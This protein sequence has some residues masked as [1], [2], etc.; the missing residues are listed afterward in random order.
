[1]RNRIFAVLVLAIVAGGGLAYATYNAINTNQ[2]VKT[3]NAPTDPVVVA[4]NDLAL[5]TELKK[6]DLMIVNFPKGSAPEGAFS[7]PS[8]L[9]GRGV[10]VPLVKNEI[11]I[12]AKLSSKEEGAG[13]PPIIPDGMRAVSV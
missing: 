2:K 4:S 8:D 9:V 10:I 5:G 11:I 7:S 6:E 1:M 12:P 13:L 3:V